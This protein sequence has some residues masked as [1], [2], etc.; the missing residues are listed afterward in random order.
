MREHSNESRQVL[1]ALPVHGTIRVLYRY[2]FGVAVGV[3]VL[4][5]LAVTILGLRY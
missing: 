3:S 4:L 5:L 2:R 1:E